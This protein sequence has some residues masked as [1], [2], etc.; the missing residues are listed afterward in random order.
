MKRL[1]IVP[2]LV[3]AVAAMTA[4]CGSSPSTAT[5]TLPPIRTTTSTTTTTTTPDLR[6]VVYIVQE[7]DN[8]SDIARDYQVTA[9]MIITLNRLPADGEIQPGQELRIPNIRVDTTRP[10]VP[11]SAS[12]SEP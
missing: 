3:G 10:T 5:G 4:S 1:T 11:S 2:L 12:T 7:G 6:D 9:A 8:V